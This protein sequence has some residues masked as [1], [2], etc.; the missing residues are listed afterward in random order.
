MD[1]FQVFH[2]VSGC[3]VAGDRGCLRGGGYDRSRGNESACSDR[4]AGAYR[5]ATDAP[6]PTEAPAPIDE[7]E[8]RAT[9]VPT[10]AQVT[11]AP[12]ATEAPSADAP[13]GHLRVAFGDIG[14]YQ[15]HPCTTGSPAVQFIT[16]TS[17]EGLVS[18]DV[19]GNYIPQIAEDWSIASDNTTWTFNLKQGVQFHGGLGELTV[20]DVM[21]SIE[22]MCEGS[23]TGI[24]LYTRPYFLDPGVMTAEDPYT[25]VTDTV[26]PRFDMLLW[27][28]S[29]GVN[30]LWIVN[31]AQTEEL[32]AAEDVAAASPQLGRHRTLGVCGLADR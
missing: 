18:N 23:A 27:L 30:G 32:V 26:E 1:E 17:F 10:V 7:E 14:S 29:P 8:D 28:S 13:Y 21:F 5:R 24:D 22:E 4:C 16:M 6:D 15:A 2:P 20:D 12:E 19:N 11:P 31:K 9:P 3:G 25:L